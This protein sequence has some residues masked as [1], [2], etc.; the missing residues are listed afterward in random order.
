MGIRNFHREPLARVSAVVQASQPISRRAVVEL[1]GDGL[2]VG[3]KEA[4]P[5]NVP[6]ADLHA[7]A[8]AKAHALD[9]GP[10]DEDAVGRVEVF[11]DVL[12][13]AT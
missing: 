11:E 8:V 1:A 5:K 6:R 9:S 12:A 13:F 4:E 10:I 3:S 7:V 2:F